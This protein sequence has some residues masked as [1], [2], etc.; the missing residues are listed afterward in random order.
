MEAVNKKIV[1]EFYKALAAH[2]AST[3]QIS[4]GGSTVHLLTNTEYNLMQLLT[5]SRVL[6][7]ANDSYKP[8]VVVSI[9]SMVV[10]EGYHIHENR[11]TNWVH[12]WTVENG[13]I[14]TQVREYLD[15]FVTVSRIIKSS[16]V[17]IPSPRSP[18][19]TKIWESELV[20]NVCVPRL[21]LVI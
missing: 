13:K 4:T 20:D 1:C 8:L 21:L 12:V 3:L 7:D 17:C 2:D 19:G 15:T 6:V 11:K 9:G 16:D 18:K 10:A 5:G 14:M